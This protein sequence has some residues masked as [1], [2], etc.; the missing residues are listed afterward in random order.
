MVGYTILISQ[1]VSWPRT[2]MHELT[3]TGFAYAVLRS[4]L[5]DEDVAT[6]SLLDYLVRFVWSE[7]GNWY[8]IDCGSDGGLVRVRAR[9][10]PSG[11]RC[12][13]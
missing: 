7:H 13:A 10:I 9:T 12:T 4:G 5:N 11:G 8:S 6:V 2:Q 1:S 3:P